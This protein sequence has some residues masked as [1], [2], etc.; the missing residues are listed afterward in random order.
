[1]LATEI[2]GKFSVVGILVI[3]III[4]ITYGL[5]KKQMP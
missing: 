5:Y 1:M 2:L 4:S 3:I